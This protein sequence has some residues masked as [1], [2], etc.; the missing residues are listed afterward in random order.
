MKFH[1]EKYSQQV[2]IASDKTIN[3]FLVGFFLVGIAF[4]FYY[5]TWLIGIGLGGLSLTAFYSAKFLFPN[6]SFY[7]YVL[8]AVF[9]IFTAQFIYQ[10]HGLFEMH[11]FAFIGSAILITYRNWKL[12]IPLAIVVFIHHA[13]FG[14]LQFFG[15]TKM[16]F[17]Q[18]E[19]MSLETFIIHVLLAITIFYICGL[20]ARNFKRAE[21]LFMQESFKVGQLQEGSAQKDVLVAMSENLRQSNAKLSAAKEELERIFNSVDQVLF[22][23]DMKTEKLIQK[24][25]KCEQIYGYTLSEF[26]ADDKLWL[27]VVHKEDLPIV[28]RME[29][30]LGEGKIANVEYRI[31]HKNKSIRWL[32]MKITPTIN[33][34]GE[35]SRIDGICN[36]ITDKKQL[37]HKLDEEKKQRQNQVTTAALAAQ[38][39]ERKFLGE[40]LHDNINPTLAAARLYIDCVIKGHHESLSLM[41]QSK[42]FIGTAMEDIRTLS[43]KLVPPSLGEIGLRD[44]ISDM[45]DNLKKAS[46][47]AFDFCWDGFDESLLNDKLKLTIYR[48]LQEQ[49][50]NINKHADA[51]NVLIALRNKQEMIELII[52]DDGKGFDISKK[53]NGVGLHNII[54]RAELFDG[55]VT[56]NSTPG[57]GCEL[58]VNFHPKIEYCI[59]EYSARA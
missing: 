18:L 12:Q 53:R 23:V 29:K 56:I 46:Q 11:F 31:I 26:K 22:S 6:S 36:D 43:R 20:W 27:K 2:K 40:E 10:M 5:N 54:S 39:N 50:N 55:R 14:Y 21:L 28:E 32:E 1:T 45:A 48:I 37:E 13:I 58:I 3:F 52:K 38:E 25:K 8:G 34:D 17:T 49:F 9:G 15:F 51:S 59:N 44:A 24:S 4:S 42:D 41:Q 16:Y 19:Y 57:N 33:L 35:L 47:L 7:Q 30:V